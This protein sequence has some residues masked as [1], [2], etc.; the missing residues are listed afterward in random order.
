M[1]EKGYTI[2]KIS[3]Y[4][5]LIY[6]KITKNGSIRNHNYHLQQIYTKNKGKFQIFVFIILEN[7]LII[8]NDF[9]KFS[10]F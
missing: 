7:V 10:H 2:P 3:I 9:S 6:V 8:F 1:Y 5:L 4:Y